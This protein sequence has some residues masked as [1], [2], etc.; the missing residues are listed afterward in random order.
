M[1]LRKLMGVLCVALIVGAATLAVAGVPDVGNSTATRA[2][3]GTE[4]LSLWNLPDGDGN[5]FTEA[6]KPGGSVADATISVVLKDGL[7]AFVKNYP[8][9]DVNLSCDS[10]TQAVVPC[11]G[12]ATADF[13]TD[14]FGWTEFRT[15]LQAGGWSL[16]NSV[17]SIA[18]APLTSGDVALTMNSSDISGD[19]NVNLTDVGMFSPI[20]YGAYSYAADFNNDNNVNLADVG[21]LA[22]GYGKKCP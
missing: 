3:T 15:P 5:P 13:N 6:F 17:V 18:G 12:G 21:R 11:P 9:E 19:G 20:F 2:Y 7:G 8:F 22:A 10:G 14:D 4:T 1:V 16:A